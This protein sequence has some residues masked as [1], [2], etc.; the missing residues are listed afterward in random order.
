MKRHSNRRTQR[1]IALITA[2]LMTVIFLVLIGGLMSQMIAELDSVGAHS[3]SAE[4]LNGAYAG[5][6]DMVLQI[7]ETASGPG[8]AA[9]S[10]INYTY[11]APSTV[12]Y[13]AS[14]TSTWNSSSGLVY[15]L[16]QSTGTED[17]SGQQRQVLAL[18]KSSP[19]S[20]F[21]QFTAGN[22]G[23]VYYVTGEH[24]DGPVYNGGTMNIWYQ[25]P[26]ASIFNST[27]NTVTTPSFYQ[28]AGKSSV[29]YGSVDWNQVTGAG[30]QGA[31]KIGTNPMQLPTFQDNLVDASEAFY[32]NSSHDSAL[33]TPGANG[34]YING[35]SA[36]AGPAGALQ[37]GLYIQGNLTMTPCSG[38]CG[39]YSGN[40]EVWT[41]K[42]PGGANGIGA[43]Y[44]VAIDYTGMTTTVTQ[45]S[46]CVT[47]CSVTYSGV[48][49]GQ[50][51]AG[52]TSAN[53]AIFDDGNVIIDS[54][55]VHGDFSIAVPDYSTN[56]AHT[57]TLEGGA[58]GVLY[59][60][61]STT[62]TD[63]LGIWANDIS[64]NSTTTTG[65]EFDGDILT[66]YFG[67]CPPCTDGTFSN[68]NYT[69]GVE[70]TFTFHGGLIQNVNGAMGI[71][72]GGVTVH[73]FDRQYVY[74][75]RLA[76]N[77]P[78]GFPITNKYDIVAWLDQGT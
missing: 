75:A 62:S 16:I 63:E 66:G 23:S 52:S 14:V 46:G 78:P 49:S 5:V 76:A 51:Q 18:V 3:R 71:S 11:P 35:H 22:S 53:G 64:V 6:E 59:K 12:S 60:D 50:P 69:G 68:K 8:H 61:Q 9:P 32:G 17:N 29:P 47:S 43:N 21:E 36:I 31:L 13:S 67:E 33:P 4:A 40:N 26:G 58:P 24:F 41:L 15:Y 44:T 74:D 25:T 34:I 45:T 37:S 77:P 27:V 19:Y 57:I 30:G 70:G 7:E 54:G 65:Y 38:S 42:N 2:L 20:Y 39:T 73:G 56:N 10:P 28:G 72:S 1:G 55:T 48:L